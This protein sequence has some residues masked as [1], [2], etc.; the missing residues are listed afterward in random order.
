MIDDASSV[1]EHRVGRKRSVA[2]LL[3]AVV[4]MVT[5]VAGV[6]SP[7]GAVAPLPAG[8]PSV[9]VP[10]TTGLVNSVKLTWLKPVPADNV[11]GYVINITAAGA[12]TPGEVPSPVAV[13]GADTLSVVVGNLV[14]TAGHTYNFTVQSVNSEGA[15]AAVAATPC[16]TAPIQANAP[17]VAAPLPIGPLAFASIDASVKRHYEEFLQ[18]DPNFSELV[19]WRAYFFN[20]RFD[21]VCA[22]PHPVQGA[23]DRTNKD[24][25]IGPFCTNEGPTT[26]GPGNSGPEIDLITFLIFGRTG[27]IDSIDPQGIADTFDRE[28]TY[29]G[30]SEPVIRLYEAYFARTPDIG[31]LKYWLG[32]FRAGKSLDDI[33][34]FFAASSEFK[35]TYGALSNADFVTLVYYNVLARAEDFGG[36]NFWRGQLDAG[37][38]RGYVMTRFSESNE[39]K[40]NI[41][42]TVKV[43][44]LYA[45][46]LGRVPTSQELFQTVFLM[47]TTW[48]AGANNATIQLISTLR[49]SPAYVAAAAKPAGLI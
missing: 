1:T 34:S 37:R 14:A 8:N 48:S 24:A 9:C 3:A 46:L 29:A 41:Y 28:T 12:T 20:H 40:S 16:N 31:G 5:I 33:S 36:Q 18:R 39:Y 25:T 19:L 15:T 11:T 32:K 17:V 45:A 13:A 35:R 10:D 23:I 42:Y 26:A 38:S 47:N 27:I 44:S 49:N 43:V 7:A 21:N 2:V 4:A 22:N 6:S 30:A